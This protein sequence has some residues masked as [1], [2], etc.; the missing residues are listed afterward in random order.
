MQRDEIAMKLDLSR[1]WSEATG[2]LRANRELVFIIA[3]LF[4]FLPFLA[5]FLHLA[6]DETANLSRGAQRTP[7]ETNLA[8][9]AFFEANWWALLLLGLAQLSGAIALIKV[10]ADA[11]RPTVKMAMAAVPI[12]LLPMIG[13]QL[14]SSLAAQVPMLLVALL[15]TAAAGLAAVLALGLV[16]YLT[17]RFSLVSPALV[18]NDWRN[19][20]AAMRESWSVTKGN[21]LRLL[22][23]F[24][25]LLVAGLVLFFVTGLFFGLLFALLGERGAQI[26]SSLFYAFFFAAVYT[27]A[28]AVIAAIYRQLTA[29]GAASVPRAGDV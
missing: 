4:L 3:G 18:L 23:F 2:M 19:P 15:P 25:L 13:T 24:A 6:G 12:L 28:Y 14:L 20:I 1:S 22:A 7:E 11:S 26:A 27:I 9:Q 8:V 17:I 5:F 21:S 29:V 10:L 16:F